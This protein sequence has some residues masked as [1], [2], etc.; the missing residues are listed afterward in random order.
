MTQTASSVC[1]VSNAN[2][3]THRIICIGSGVTL[4]E[5]LPGYGRA[6][7]RGV[8][9]SGSVGLATPSACRKYATVSM[10]SLTQCVHHA[11]A[12]RPSPGNMVTKA[13]DIANV[14]SAGC[15]VEWT[16]RECEFVSKL[17][18]LWLHICVCPFT[19]VL[20]LK[21]Q[22]PAAALLGCNPGSQSWLLIRTH[23]GLAR[24]CSMQNEICKN[25]TRTRQ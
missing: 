12:R 10:N 22:E 6:R 21:P 1:S 25:T 16:L 11:Y 23:H 15:L 9:R 20:L 2:V 18:T 17:F 14:S 7:Y 13:C 19:L 8:M 3:L 24:S 4:L 5:T